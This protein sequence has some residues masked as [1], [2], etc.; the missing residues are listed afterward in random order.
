MAFPISP[1]SE[2]AKFQGRFRFLSLDE[3]RKENIN[4]MGAAIRQRKKNGSYVWGFLIQRSSSS[5]LN[6]RD[7]CLGRLGCLLWEEKL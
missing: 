7:K 3:K 2:K 1:A 6:L 5:L 4:K